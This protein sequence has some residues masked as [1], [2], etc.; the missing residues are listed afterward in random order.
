MFRLSHW[1]GAQMRKLLS[2]LYLGASFIKTFL[3]GAS[4]IEALHRLDER[5]DQKGLAVLCT[6]KK[7]CTHKSFI[8]DQKGYDTMYQDERLN[9]KGRS[10]RSHKSITV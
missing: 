8:N 5:P 6:T 10:E 4:F 2:L 1:S 7:D 9:Q 3:V